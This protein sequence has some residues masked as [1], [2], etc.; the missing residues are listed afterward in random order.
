MEGATYPAKK[1][2]HSIM[3]RHS[4]SLLKITILVV[5]VCL[6]PASSY[7]HEID[8]AANLLAHEPEIVP[9]QQLPAAQRYAALLAWGRE[10][11]AVINFELREV[12]PHNWSAFAN[13]DLAVCVALERSISHT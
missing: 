12:Q 1:K 8:P 4:S 6:I 10:N 3:A 13:K 7:A 5:V 11:G 2:S 9:K